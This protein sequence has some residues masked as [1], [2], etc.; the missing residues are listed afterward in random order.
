MRPF[1]YAK[2]SSPSAAIS[3]VAANAAARYIAGGTNLIDLMQDTV[4]SPQLVVDI[5]ALPYGA[6]ARESSFIRIGALARMSDTADHAAVKSAAPVVSEALDASASA[7]LRNQASIGGN[8]MQRTRC[9]YFRDVATACNKRELGQGCAAIRGENRMHAILG[10]SAKCIC[11]HASDLAVALLAT[12]ALIRV[13]GRGGERTIP[14]G[15]FHMLPGETPAL[16]TALRHGELITA[17]DIPLSRVAAHS[18]YLKVR[19]RMSY[20]FALVSVA[21]ALDVEGGRIRDARLAL[22][23]VAPVPWR[24]RDAERSLIGAPATPASFAR[25]AEVALSGAR[26]YGHNDFKI[27]LARRT[28]VRA[29]SQVVA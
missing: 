17:V 2:T 10:T 18:R 6:I 1:K 26:G 21:A 19:D 4:E 25:A 16:E 14:I 27:P 20:E 7:Q 24:A 15:E 29:L 8:L 11:V 13:R 23:G 5:N 9:A 22:G 28:I 12:D 3:A